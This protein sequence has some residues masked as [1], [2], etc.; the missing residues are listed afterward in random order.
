[1]SSTWRIMRHQRVELAYRLVPRHRDHSRIGVAPVVAMTVSPI[2]RVVR[3]GFLAG[4]L[5][6]GVELPL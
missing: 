6:R 3:H 2:C 1:M 4:K 5:R